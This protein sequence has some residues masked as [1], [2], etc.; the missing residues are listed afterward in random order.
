MNYVRDWD[1][2]IYYL[3]PIPG[4]HPAGKDLRYDATYD[5][6]KDA[7]RQEDDSLPQ[8]IWKRELKVAQ[9]DK[10]EL[11]CAQ[12]LHDRTKDLQIAAWLM[13]S[14]YYQNGIIGL[15]H[16]AKVL[17][18]LCER[19]WETLYPALE[20]DD[21][22]YRL[23]PID[24]INEKVQEHLLR[25][26]VSFPKEETIRGFTFSEYEFLYKERPAQSS[27]N[28]QSDLTLGN[29]KTSI[30]NTQDYIYE[31]LYQDTM[32]TI[33]AFEALEKFLSDRLPRNRVSLY[34]IRNILSRYRDFCLT[35][36]SER[37]LLKPK[38]EKYAEIN[39]A[40]AHEETSTVDQESN[41][42]K[43]QIDWANTNFESREQAYAVLA[44]IAQYLEAIE[45]HSPTPYLLK[46]AISWG[47]MHLNQLLQEFIENNMDFAQLQK[48]LG[49]PP[50]GIGTN[51]NA[52]SNQ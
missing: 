11:L 22:E 28:D 32:N 16:G 17:I 10:V 39:P 26:P 42:P 40:I 43:V 48:W 41:Q 33:E 18:G 47:N 6:I 29:L 13:E 12:A 52:A 19:Y 7:R 38:W 50:V 34:K 46:K 1:T 23:A 15:Y 20:E 5:Q 36:L 37:D 24:W 31:V 45:P 4:T 44:E 8:G 51:R 49:I 9:W 30:A 27:A 2:Y 14:W 35:V 25:Y 3:E 21:V